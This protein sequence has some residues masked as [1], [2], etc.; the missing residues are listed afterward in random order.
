MRRL[1]IVVV[2]LVGVLA[3]GLTSVG[4]QDQT[5]HQALTLARIHKIFVDKMPNDLD[6]Y[7]NAEIA[8]QMPGRVTVVLHK[9]D[10]DAVGRSTQGGRSPRERSQKGPRAGV[11]PS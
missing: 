5:L 8:K 11:Q 9:E 2:S 6:Q 10:A 7:I 1:S 4:A 3:V